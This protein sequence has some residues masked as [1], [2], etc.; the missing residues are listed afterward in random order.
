MDLVEACRAFVHVSERNSFTVGAAAAGVSQSVAS[1]R[2]AALERHLGRSLLER[3]SRHTTPTPF[4][5]HLLPAARRLV[6]AAEALEDEAERAH[7]APIGLALPDTC[8][9]PEV[10]R[11]IAAAAE[12][13]IT[14]DPRSAP[15]AERAELLASRTVRA[16]LLAVPPTEATW[17]VPLGLAGRTPPAARRLYVETLRPARGDTGSARRLCLEPEDDVPHVRDRLRRV[18]ESVGLRPSQL[19]VERSPEVAAARALGGEDL[20]L[21]PPARARE[22]GLHWRPI[23]ELD[24]VRGYALVTGSPD[25][26]DRLAELP[27]EAIARCPGAD[28]APPGPASDVPVADPSPRTFRTFRASRG[29]AR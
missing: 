2:V 25:D 29:S 1:R 21:C 14:L 9:R 24:P 22:L 8:S 10:A 13:G 11:L 23:G 3:G 16:A 7:R 6:L 19:I 4:G 18:C 27:G 20:L 17:T 28:A 12:R 5:R 15:P 26:A